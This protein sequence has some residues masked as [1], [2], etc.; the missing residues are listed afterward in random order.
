V[1]HL[2]T[3]TLYA[4]HPTPHTPTPQT[5]NTRSQ[6]LFAATLFYL[7]SIS[8]IFSALCVHKKE[9]IPFILRAAV[10][11]APIA[12]SEPVAFAWR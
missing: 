12:L 9:K 2:H 6:V 5:P 4:I 7:A 8:T 3:S 10:R 1:T 11:I